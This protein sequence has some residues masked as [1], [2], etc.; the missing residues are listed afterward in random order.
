MLGNCRGNLCAEGT[1][2]RCLRIVD[3]AM[4]PK[5][6]GQSH[7]QHLLAM[8][9]SADCPSISNSQIFIKH[10]H[11]DR[12]ILA[13]GAIILLRMTSNR[14]NDKELRSSNGT[15]QALGD[16]EHHDTSIDK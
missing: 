1:H 2:G 9:Q 16:R 11:V 5:T 3:H 13:G 7:P 14:A 15:V 12:K 10:K 8:G 4:Y 6:P